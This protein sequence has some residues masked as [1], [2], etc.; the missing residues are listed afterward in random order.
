MGCAFPFRTDAGRGGCS[1]LPC[2]SP[3]RRPVSV[4]LLGLLLTQQKKTEVRGR[5]RPLRVRLEFATVV[6]KPKL[7]P[8]KGLMQLIHKLDR[9]STRLNSSH[10]GISY[11]V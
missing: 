7:E 4:V 5:Y 3:C 9:K 11:A 1:L 10:L 2:A 8:K 6:Q